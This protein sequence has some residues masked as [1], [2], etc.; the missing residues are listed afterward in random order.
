[1]KLS[2]SVSGL[3]ALD[4]ALGNLPKATA[5]NVVK[6]TLEKAAVP[7]VDE[8]RRLA[9]IGD[10]GKLHDS[11]AV[12]SRVKNKVG[13]AEYGAAMRAGLGTAAA[14]S[15]LRQ[16]RRNSPGSGA[17]AQVFIGPSK[18]KGVLGY[19]SA[20]EFGTVKM[21][22]KPYMRPAWD[23]TK[24]RCLSIIK[25]ELRDQIIMAARRVGRSKKQ[26][27]EAKFSASMAALLAHEAT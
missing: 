26:S 4:K 13:M 1:M 25:G 22:P 15:A 2:V 23:A 16:A 20:V 19:A 21:P 12:S 3:A 18:G 17:F 24:D 9:P 7:M 11:I 27:S 14:R 8:A 5:R 6:R 10:T